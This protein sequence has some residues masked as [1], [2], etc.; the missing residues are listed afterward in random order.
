MPN[1]P[2]MDFLW[3]IR[4]WSRIDMKLNTLTL[5]ETITKLKAKE[6]SHTELYKDV[7]A[8]I[9][10][11]NEN[12]NVY[13]ALDN[14]AVAKAEKLLDTPLAGAPIAVKD[15]YLTVGLAT[16]ASSNVLRGFK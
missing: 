2:I 13:L 12:L 7:H 16:T 10:E 15:N 6:I 11:K 14:E 8:Q 9:E 1:E 5:T 3:W 4:F